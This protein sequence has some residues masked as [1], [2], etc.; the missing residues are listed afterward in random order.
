MPTDNLTFF[1]IGGAIGLISAGIGAVFDYFVNQR[2]SLYAENG[3]PGCMFIVAGSLGLA[4]VAA[5]AVSLLFTHSIQAAVVMGLGVLTGF[6]IGFAT[7]FVVAV[8]WSSK[9][10]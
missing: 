6:F 3:L 2:R 8:L 7:L 1:L 4:G 5:T 9:D 10:N